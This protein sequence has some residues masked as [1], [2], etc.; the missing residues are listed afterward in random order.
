MKIIDFRCAVIGKNPV[1]RIVTDAGID[2]YGEAESYK[3]YLKAHVLAL[4]DAV[5]G[6][7]PTDVER[8]MLRIRSRGALKPWGSAV[9]VVEHALWDIAGKAAGVPVYKLLG[10]K[11]TARATASSVWPRSSRSPPRSRTI[12]SSSST[13]LAI[14]PG[15]M[16]SSTGC[17][18]RS[19]RTG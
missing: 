6:E 16:T 1:V 9:S 8:V 10:G 2:G 15:G 3:P 12:S 14:P 7:D 5:I 19:S 4:R 11:S 13:R 17:P 18:I